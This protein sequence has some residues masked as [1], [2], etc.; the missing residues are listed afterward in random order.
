MIYNQKIKLSIAWILSIAVFA[1]AGCIENNDDDDTSSDRTALYTKQPNKQSRWA[2]FENPTAEKGKAGLENKGAKGHAFDSIKPGET[3]VLLDVHGSGVVNRMWMTM[4]PRS[5]ELLRSLRIEMFWDDATTPAVS[6]P[7][8]DF[9][10]HIL[11][12][13]VPVDNELFSNPNGNAF[14]CY[15]PMPFEKAARISVVN[16]SE[17]TFIQFYYDVNFYLVDR[18]EE[19]ALYFHAY[20]RHERWTELGKDYEILPQ[21]KGEGRYL[22]THIGVVVRPDNIGWWGEGGL[23][24]YLDGDTEHPT[25]MGTGTE[26]YMGAAWGMPVFKSRYQGCLITDN[27]RGLHAFYRYHVPDPIY[28]HSDCRVTMQ[29]IGC[30]HWETA[31]ALMKKG[32]PFKAHSIFFVGEAGT[33]FVRLLDMDPTP[34]LKDISVP[35]GFEH[36]YIFYYRTDDWSSVAFF[37]L[38]KPE[39]GLPKIADK[40]DRILGI[41]GNIQVK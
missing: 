20:W 24:V 26:D 22:G 41:E 13:G 8:G 30:T 15:I 31:H 9:F 40:D 12:Q 5:P 21:I 32:V 6:A 28:F 19:D 17:T 38:D 18:P 23:K 29:Q 2:S 34:E 27:K 25:L 7:L 39:N 14:N 35:E 11:G 33:K 37:Y 16:D 36:E 4:N 10:C 1:F 3:K